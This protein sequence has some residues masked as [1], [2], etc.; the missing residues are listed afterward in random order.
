VTFF[1]V[2]VV[3]GLLAALS[4]PNLMSSQ[5]R[6]REA[7]LLH[8]LHTTMTAPALAPI[9]KAV[10][11]TGVGSLERTGPPFNT[12]AYD[13]IYDNPFLS[14]SAHPL[15]T[16]S[17]DTDTASYSNVR[18][19][20]NGG[21]LPPRDAVR[22][23]E[24]VNYFRFEYPQSEGD[25]PF[26][27]TTELAGCP[28]N[29]G[30]KLALIGLQ[31][32]R[33]EEKDLP[34]RNLVFLVDV[35]GSMQDPL[36]LPLV[37]AAMGMLV[38]SLTERD[39][40]AIVVYAG[41]TGL[42]LPPRP[43]NQKAAIRQALA[44]LEAGGS[45]NGGQGIVLAY[46]VAEENFIQ[47]GINRVILATDGDFNVGV[48]SQGDLIRLI[49]EKRATGIFLSVLGVG[50][51]NLKD[52]TMEN[53][54]DK[55]NG[56]YAYLDS[57][58]EARKVLV[59]EAGGTLVTIAKDVK[60]QVEFN[61]R[62]V[63][64]YRLIGYENR[65]LRAEDFSDDR[66]DAGEIGAGHTV[67]ALYELIPAGAR[68]EASQADALKYQGPRTPSAAAEGD[69]V[70]TVQLRYKAPDG[71]RS[72]LLTVAVTDPG[73]GRSDPSRNMRFAGAVVGFGMLL[74]DSEH[75]GSVSYAQVLELARGSKGEDPH[76]YRAEFIKLVELA[77]TLAKMQGPRQRA[78]S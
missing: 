39:R 59:S 47:G 58:A 29:P 30:H 11:L 56:N 61:P 76:G 53:L 21:R 1:V 33:I 75:K 46:K 24:M 20:L 38:E 74:R 26:S 31:G 67:T 71:D 65:M 27:V 69:E 3:L 36:K 63:S 28:W 19:F 66:R 62:E 17:I 40:V 55:G 14:V 73:D 44:S 35:S 16:F 12:E 41:S 78:G 9:A 68:V 49:E 37:K 5:R 72:A 34:P 25:A 51:G 22:I 57:L 50:E 13:R 42:V 23:E 48:T 7:R 8:E 77:E 60:I 6:S 43:G 18:R 52:S 4:I 70:M 2:L 32:K 45:T 15:S 54:A 10:P 64:A